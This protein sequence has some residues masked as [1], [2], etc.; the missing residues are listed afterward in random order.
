MVLH[1]SG[2]GRT[3]FH[4]TREAKSLPE[5]VRAT[6]LPCIRVRAGHILRGGPL[7]PLSLEISA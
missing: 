3:Q 6:L 2:T 4:R 7:Q 1:K 5:R